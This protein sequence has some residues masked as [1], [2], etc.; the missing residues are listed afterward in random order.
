MTVY[1]VLHVLYDFIRGTT[2]HDALLKVGDVHSLVPEKTAVMAFTA[3]ATCSL[4][5]ELTDKIGMKQPVVIVLLPCKPNL[6][7]KVMLFQSIKES[8]TPLLERLMKERTALPRMIIY[9]Q[10]ME[11]CAN[12][13]L[14]LQNGLGKHYFTEPP[15]VPSLSQFRL[16]EMF[17]S[18]T[19]TAVMNKIISLFSEP[20]SLR[21]AVFPQHLFCRVPHPV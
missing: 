20:S 4:R 21:I 11:D 13:Y 9:C 1:S 7:Y 8:F 12:L 15:G 6:M 17:T 2:L 18:C 3:T 19:D 5:L 10:K 14:F 16:V